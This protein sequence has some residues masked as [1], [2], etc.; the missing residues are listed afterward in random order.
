MSLHVRLAGLIALTVA[1]ALLV[2]GLFG[3]LDF[4]RSAL[5]DVNADLNSY[6]TALAHDRAT[7]TY[8][9]AI[10][11]ESGIRAQ[12]VQGGRTLQEYG[13]A[14]PASTDPDGDTDRIVRRVGVPDLGAG[15]VLEASLSLHASNLGHA[16]RDAL[17]VE[18]VNLLAQQEVFEQGRAAHADLEGILVVGDGVPHVVGEVRSGLHH[19]F[20]EVV[21]FALV[22]DFP[23]HVV[24][25]RKWDCAAV[26]CAAYLVCS[27]P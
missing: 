13:G 22:G 19:V 17:V 9:N 11:S 5:R 23:C 7:G 8:P 16:L 25:R 6:L 15:A 14:F 26:D 18:M 24:L 3:Y 21:L 20:E 12:L 4:R 2:Q 1:L 27:A 10:E